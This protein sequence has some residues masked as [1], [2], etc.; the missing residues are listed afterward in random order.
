MTDRGNSAANRD[1]AFHVHG[2]TNLK[3]HEERGPL[4]ITGGSGIR[5]TDDTGKSY[6]EGLAGLWCTSLG[7]QEDRLI[8]A[9][10]K[11]CAIVLPVDGVVAR[12]FKA[13]AAHETG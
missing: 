13:G 7:F 10:T 12:E 2:Y 3:K 1:I 5:V 6:I 4:I 9:A 8:E 11:G